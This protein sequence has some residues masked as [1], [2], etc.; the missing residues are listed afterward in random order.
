MRIGQRHSSA[1]R[2]NL[3]QAEKLGLLSIQ[4]WNEPQCYTLNILSKILDL[5]RHKNKVILVY[6]KIHCNLQFVSIFSVV[7]AWHGWVSRH[8]R[9]HSRC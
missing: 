2:C 4:D 6:D 1:K 8:N 7:A 5:R 9:F 3:C